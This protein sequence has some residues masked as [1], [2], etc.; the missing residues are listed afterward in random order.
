MLTWFMRRR[1]L[2]L[3]CAELSDEI[4][5]EE[6]RPLVAEATRRHRELLSSLL[7]EETLGARLVM[8]FTTLG[9]ASFGAIEAAGVER[10][11]AIR[12]IARANQRILKPLLSLASVFA[13]SLGRRAITRSRRIWSFLNG[14]F[15]FAPPAWRRVDVSR[16]LESFGFDYGSCPIAAFSREQGALDLCSRAFCEV[17]HWIGDAL[18]VQLERSETIALGHAHC[19]FRWRAVDPASALPRDASAR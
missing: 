9:I 8:Q 1:F 2:K 13:Y 10:E 17:D 4:D 6:V 12:I 15:P 5:R 16:G 3:C 19:R 11:E 14:T 18:K 7:R